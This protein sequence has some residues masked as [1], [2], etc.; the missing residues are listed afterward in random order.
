MKYV[1]NILFLFLLLTGGAAGQRDSVQMVQY[2]PDF[3]FE[4]GI[5]LNFQMV[6]NNRP[7]AKSRILTSVPYD[8]R[9]FYDRVLEEDFVFF[10]DELGMKRKVPTKDIWGYARNGALFIGVNKSYYRVTIVGSICHFVADITTQSTRYYDPYYYY[11]PY[12]TYYRYGGVPTTTTS[13][14][15]RQFV[16][17]FETGK[18]LEY[19]HE[20]VAALLMKDPELYDEFSQ[21]R[22][23]KRRQ[24]KFLYIRKFNER[25][26]LY[27]PKRN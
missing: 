15:L 14:E 25:N 23:K 7:L 6:K 2:T 11:N 1:V 12:S 4:D 24:L 21:L 9:D 10:Y 17:D 16:L 3:E 19:D 22:K 20:S 8:E 5:Y 13:T 18:V 26:P 27:L